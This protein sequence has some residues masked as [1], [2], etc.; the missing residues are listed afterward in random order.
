MRISEIL[1]KAADALDARG[2]IQGDYGVFEAPDK[3]QCAMCAYGALYAVTNGTGNPFD[4]TGEGDEAAAFLA[5]H[6]LIPEGADGGRYLPT[7]NDYVAETKEDVTAVL[8]KGAE[9][10][11][12]QGR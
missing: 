7:W 10:A 12:E 4:A 3:T 8:R 11:K 5:S 9:L 1:E 6:D 2:W